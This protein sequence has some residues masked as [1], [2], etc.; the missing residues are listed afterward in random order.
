VGI[1]AR[2]LA[3]LPC[4]HWMRSY[5]R[6]TLVSD[7]VAALIVT[8]MLIP[9]SLAYSMLAGLPPEVGL[10]ASVAPLVAYAV[11]GSSRVLSVG[12]VA[13]TS[14]MAATALS[15]WAVAG[16]PAYL[17]GALVLAL[18]SGFMLMAMGVMRLGFLAN[19]LSTPVTSGFVSASS[20]LIALGQAGH[21][22]GVRAAGDTLP[23][24]LA[25]LWHAVPQLRP[26]TLAVGLAVVVF[27][28][29]ARSGLRTLLK[30][31]GTPPK[32]A[33]LAAK[34]GPVVAI[35]ASAVWVS[36][37]GW[38]RDGPHSLA[39][40]VVGAI[41]QGLPPFTWPAWHPELWHSLLGPALLISVVG[42][43]QSLSASQTLAARRR[44]RISPNAELLALGAS[45]LAAGLT[46]GLP[47][48]GGLSR[49]VVNDDAGA[50]TP[51][52]GV[53]TAMGILLASL[54]LTPWLYHLPQATLA[55]TII[56]AVLTLI[57]VDVLRRTWRY[58]KPD[59]VAVAVTVVATLL[60]GVNSGLVAG[61]AVSL[62]LY[63][64]HTSRPH[65]AVVGRVPGTEH[66]RNVQRHDVECQP[67]VLGLRVDESLY[68]ANARALEDRINLEVA[69]RPGLRHVVLQCTAINNIDAS[70]LESLE[71][72]DQRLKE[73]GIQLH[74]SE[75][76][77]PVMD[78]LQRSD[79]LKHLSGRVF[80][81]HHQ[82]VQ[83]LTQGQRRQDAD[84]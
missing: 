84:T 79:W 62:V 67:Q 20:V 14:L 2:G 3:R 33:D 57:D 22:M 76:K 61:V 17:E 32:V 31:L 5:D 29:W 47:V 65:I 71:T 38:E 48:T 28:L 18:L 11:L 58:D 44:Q 80:M 74:L 13:I 49:S 42:Y 39:V 64:W 40:K 34:M 9:Q 7:V 72:I 54:L 51:A 68:F 4:A 19:F 15:P 60:T 73:A 45:N 25:A 35:V 75:V 83:A 82:A 21:L 16:S 24:Q 53:F 70:A 77:G 50:Q 43:V 66:F 1:L 59:F 41:P 78:K 55:A 52:A 12:P 56:V 69:Q 26:T 46:G 23:Q 8:V 6:A 30:R 81:T 36:T 37:M 63:L 10:Y 27:L